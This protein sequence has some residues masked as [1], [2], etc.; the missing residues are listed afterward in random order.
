MKISELTATLNFSEFDYVKLHQAGFSKSKL[1]VIKS[2]LPIDELV[3]QISRKKSWVNKGGRPETLHLEAQICLMFLKS[4]TGLSD[5]ELVSRLNTDIHY[6]FFC[7]IYISPD[8]PIEDLKI[9]SR[10]RTKL[11]KRIDIDKFQKII[12]SALKPHISSNDLKTVVSDATCYESYLRFPTNQKLLMEGVEWAFSVIKD[13]RETHANRMPRTK[14]VDVKRAYDVFARK[15]KKSHKQKR[16]ITIRLL[17]LLD[18]LLG[19]IK[20][21]MNKYECS[22]NP[23]DAKKYNVTKS[24]L[25]QQQSLFVG[26]KVSNRIVSIHKPYIRPIVRGKE[27]KEVEFGAKVNSIQVGGFNFIEK[28]DFNAFHEGIRVPQCVLLH[29]MLFHTKTRFF[30]GDAIYATN[31]NRSYCKA[32]NIITN[33]V[34]KGR[35][36]K[37]DDVVRGIRRDLN[38]LRSTTLEGSFGVEKNCFSL[39][40]VKAR[41]KNNEVLW[42]LFGIHAANFS[43]LAN[44]LMLEQKESR[45]AA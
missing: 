2:L 39:S 17:S 18:K 5:A 11:A 36:P 27:V 41:T 16:K 13:I 37:N 22:L 45:K 43:R 29:K 44:R 35:R 31:S 25:K 4:M 32:N 26:E 19:L 42:I 21:L 7:N 38:I 15:R 12:A 28:L 1:G 24:V 34:P 14:Y 6:Q 20:E 30:A 9:A 8:S 3:R 10:I 40:K 33:F 23:K